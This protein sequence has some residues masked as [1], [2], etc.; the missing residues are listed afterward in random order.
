M[1]S[2]TGEAAADDAAAGDD[3][4]VSAGAMDGSAARNDRGPRRAG[5]PAGAERQPPW[6][7]RRSLQRPT[8]RPRGNFAYALHEN[9]NRTMIRQCTIRR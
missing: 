8:R 7:W 6:E 3:D 1:T 4:G 9:M 5:I 2:N